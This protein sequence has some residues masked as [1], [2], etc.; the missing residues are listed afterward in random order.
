MESNDNNLT[1]INIEIFSPQKRMKLKHYQQQ[2]T[3]V[4]AEDNDII[5]ESEESELFSSKR[6]VIPGQIISREGE[7]LKGHGTFHNGSNLI[8]SVCGTL[9]KVDR[10]ISVK[11]LKSRYHGEV[12]DIIVGRITEISSKRWKVDVNSRLD[13]ILMLS[14]INLPGGIQRRRTSADELQMRNFFVENDLVYAE[15]QMIMGDGSV[16]IHTRNQKYG[17]LQNGHFMKVTPSLIKR[18]K[19]HFYSLECGVDVILGLNG[20]I[21]I[22]D[23][24]QQKN[25]SAFIQKHEKENFDQACII[26]D[27]IKQ[28]SKDSRDRIS[29][30]KNSI[31]L[32][33]KGFLLIHSKS[34]MQVYHL[35]NKMKL[36]AKDLLHPQY[37]KQILTLLS[38]EYN[39][40][41]KDEE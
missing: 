19:Q 14:A 38:T 31:A 15:V 17:K 26:P 37:I 22:A 34:I 40:D 12:G 4:K 5:M 2:H 10:L 8:A 27:D 33:E 20:Y 32:L 11:A 7:Y 6:L 36:G 1:N 16:A 3:Q 29:R 30:V 21:W 25:Q 23:T 35:S 39:D 18:S 9:D 28:I 13:Y 24:E 41:I